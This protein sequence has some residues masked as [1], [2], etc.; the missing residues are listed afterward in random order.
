MTGGVAYI[1]DEEANFE[2]H[3]NP[4]LVTPSR[5]EDE[6][7]INTLKALIYRH[8]ELTESQRASEILA[9]WPAHQ[10]MF[11]KVSPI[12]PPPKTPPAAPA[13]TKSSEPP[14]TPQ[15]VV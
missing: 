8:L 4:Q 7:D 9:D 15:A 14:A 11:W 3:Y 10:P 2:N 13:E 6:E 5:L 1:L 12:A